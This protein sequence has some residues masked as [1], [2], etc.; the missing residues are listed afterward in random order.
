M[1]EK[2]LRR[3]GVIFVLIAFIFMVPS[4]INAATLKNEPYVQYNFNNNVTDRKGHSELTVL[5]AE[6]D[7][8]NRNNSSTSYG[9]DSYGPYFQWE[10]SMING[11]GF[12][13]DIDKNIGEEYTIGLKFSFK[14]TGP[15][16]RKI[17]DYG[18][19]LSD[20]GFY[21]YSNGHLNFFNYG[22][23][24]KSIT[25]ANEVIDMIVRRNKSGSFEAYIVNGGTKTLDL[26]IT[27]KNKWGVPIIIDGKTRIGFFFDDTDTLDSSDAYDKPEAATGGKVYDI[28]IWD[29]YVDPDEVIEELKPKGF[30]NVHYV[31]ED[32]NKIKDDKQ[33]EGEKGENYSVSPDAI[34][35][36]RYVK[37]EGNASGTFPEGNT[38]VTFVYKKIIK[39]TV[40]AKFVD[41]NGNK[42]KDDK[43]YE[44]EKDEPYNISKENIYGYEYVR[45]E[46]NSSGVFPE[47]NTDVTFVYK[48]SMPCTVTA[49][50]V[51]EDGNKLCDNIVY[52][53]FENNAY[54]TSKLEIKGYEFLRVEGNET[55]KFMY[56]PQIV[57]Y[58]YKKESPPQP[59]KKGSV[60][61]KYVDEAGNEIHMDLIYKGKVGDD[62]KT[63]QL[64]IPG[65]EFKEVIGD[66]NGKFTEGSK[67]VRYIYTKKSPD[68][69]TDDNKGGSVVIRYEDKDGNVIK[70]D[71]V[72]NGSVGDNYEVPKPNIPGYEV[73][74][75]VGEEKGKIEEDVKVVTVVYSPLSVGDTASSVVA[76]YVDINGNTIHPDNVYDG[77][78]GDDYKTKK[79][80]IKGFELVK[81]EG[82]ESGKFAEDVKVVTYVYKEVG[83]V[84]VK[85]VDEKGN[86]IKKDIVYTGGLE[87]RYDIKYPNI[88]GYE[89]VKTVGGQSGVYSRDDQEI[90]FVYK[91]AKNVDSINKN[92]NNTNSSGTGSGRDVSN[93]NTP[94]S[95]SV[96]TSDENNLYLYLFFAVISAGGVMYTI[97]KSKEA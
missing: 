6:G 21:F 34:E 96:K 8:K 12:Y 90:I 26:Q 27:D 75:V 36:Y 53:G 25:Q 41:I 33:I 95:G 66:R 50:Y 15:S 14:E 29:K 81:V 93:R 39:G 74:K 5:S 30:V 87:E 54:K 4:I 59:V 17:I 52:K 9:S 42:I 71:V 37:T 57:T 19:G 22:T 1:K 49:I 35:G 20:V 58:V 24:G 7:D 80:N 55:G 60:T 64:V 11:G 62:Y 77:Q 51:D 78:I 68:S 2:L 91:K 61:A 44:G 56:T 45:T 84:T 31:N 94:P 73:D 69:V 85:F 65:Y 18:D 88:K 86:I 28:K 70:E 43:I 46:G 23:N 47:R 40:T 97:K 3:K 92:N 10:S 32:G 72:H 89:Y 16:W 48:V 83:K 82:S 38:N 67:E 79:E 13:I 76:R 63:S